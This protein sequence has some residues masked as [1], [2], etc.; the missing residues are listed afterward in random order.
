M[1]VL[2]AALVC[3]G[4]AAVPALGADYETTEKSPL[5]ELHLRIPATAMKI[6]PLKEKILSMYWADTD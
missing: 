6:V 2:A 1:K 3:V 5:Y 4:L